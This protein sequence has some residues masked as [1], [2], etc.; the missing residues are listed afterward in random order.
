[1]SRPAEIS[2][3]YG[4]AFGVPGA[5]ASLVRPHTLSLWVLDE[6]HRLWV[7]IPATQNAMATHQ[8]TTPI[9]RFSVF[10]LMGSPEGSARDTYVFP[11]PWR[12]HGP[13]AGNGPGQTGTLTDGLTFSNIPSECT[14]R[15]FTL[16]GEQVREIHHSDLGGL[17]AQEIWD[18]KTPHGDA[19]ASGVY[20]WRVESSLD[21]KN[22][23]LMII[24]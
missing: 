9:T 1:L 22:G 7:K 2:I 15:I 6:A 5:A 21:G 19:V 8:L 14:I 24:R 3:D 11:V 17:I 16:S 18:A 20:L 4:A 10:A 13:N 12:P 23:K